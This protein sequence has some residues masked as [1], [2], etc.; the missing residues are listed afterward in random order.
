MTGADVATW[1]KYINH[2]FESWNI[3]YRIVV[4][5]DYGVATRSATATLLHALGIAQV[6]LTSGVT[7]ALRS[8]VRNRNLT[9]AERARFAARV[10]WRRRLR[11]K[12]NGGGV[13]PPLAKII[14]SSW[15]WAPPGHD[16]VDLI[17]PASAPLY[18]MVRSKVIRA[19]T[20][21][22]WGK[23]PSGDVSKGDGIIILEVL[24][25]VGKFKKG[26][27]LCYGHAEEPVVKVGDVVN[28]GDH[29]GRAGLAVAWHT[30]FMVHARN[31]ARGTG[32][33]DPMPYVNYAIKHA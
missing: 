16:G 2:Q 27:R 21:G 24:Q 5:G 23:A 26:M 32:D 17:C 22:W 28:A 20:G 33:R 15:G 8:K 1:Q 14:E 25:N 4:D 6:A 9:P 30:H 18:A 19:D 31:D 12:H 29:I 13:A 10:V 3:G 11:D 7:P